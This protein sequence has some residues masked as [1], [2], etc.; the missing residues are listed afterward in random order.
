MIE[1][2]TKISAFIPHDK[3]YSITLLVLIV[4]EI[5]NISFVSSSWILFLSIPQVVY[6]LYLILSNKLEKA[7]LLHL[8]FNLTACDINTLDDDITMLSYPA[9]KLIGPLT[10]SYLLLGFIWLKTVKKKIQISNNQLLF[11]VRKV[12]FVLLILGGAI[13]GI[14]LGL[15]EYLFRDYITP[16]RYIVVGFLYVDIFVRMYNEHLMKECYKIALSLLIA[17]PIASLIT[18]FILQISYDYS[19]FKSFLASPVMSLSPL[20]FLFLIIKTTKIIKTY[21]CISMFCFLLLTITSGRGGNFLNMAVILAIMVYLIYFNNNMYNYVNIKLF[22]VVFPL[23]CFGLFVYIN[24]MLQNVGENMAS[25]KLQQFITLFSILDG[26][27]GLSI[28][29]IGTSPYVRIAEILNVVDNALHNPLYLVFGKGYGGYYTDSL[30]LF[31]G[32]DLTQG[33]FSFEAVKVGRFGTAHSMYPN[34]LLFHGLIGFFLIIRIGFRYL[35]NIDR[36][37]LLFAAFTLFLYSFYY[38]VALLTACIMFLFASE[39]YL[40]PSKK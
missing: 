37:P 16:L 12:F 4:L 34:V 23:V 24:I 29:N 40:N 14:G 22:K 31:S 20:L 6:V 17:T 13:G 19:V 35:K 11:Q 38:N 25:N 33:A 8:I 30:G 39:L 3:H 32:I 10:I 18:F 26:D 2:E 28:D 7:L 1:R 9:I 5:I 27:S 15:N 36:T 21:M